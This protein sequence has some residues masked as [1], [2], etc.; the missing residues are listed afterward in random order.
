MADK[1]QNIRQCQKIFKNVA[2]TPEL[3]DRFQCPIS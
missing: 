3:C 2:I 1:I